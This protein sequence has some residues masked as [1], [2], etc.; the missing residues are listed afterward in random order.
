[1]TLKPPRSSRSLWEMARIILQ[2]MVAQ[3]T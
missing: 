3:N 2:S 1:M